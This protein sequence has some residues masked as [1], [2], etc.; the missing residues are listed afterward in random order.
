L[1]I[2][3]IPEYIHTT[4]LLSLGPRRD[5]AIP[6]HTAILRLLVSLKSRVALVKTVHTE[7]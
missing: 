3:D 4:T 5:R 6:I 1:Y 7:L 2:D